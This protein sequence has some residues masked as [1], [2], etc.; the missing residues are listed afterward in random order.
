MG[1][2]DGRF[3]GQGGSKI[4]QYL[5]FG[6]GV[7]RAEAI[8]EDHNIRLFDQGPGN[9]YPLFLSTREGHPTFTNQGIKALR[10]LHYIV[11]D[12]SIAGIIFDL[13]LR[14][15]PFPKSNIGRNGI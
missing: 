11:V 15:I 4:F 14:G 1:D 5:L 2:D 9:G 12:R 10:Q 7:Y 13:R 8:V 6:I 3:V